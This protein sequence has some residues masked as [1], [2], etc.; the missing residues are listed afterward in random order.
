MLTRRALAGPIF[1]AVEDGSVVVSSKLAP[2]V[3]ALRRRP[4]ISSRYLAWLLATEAPEDLAS[5]TYEGV[6]RVPTHHVV[7]VWPDGRRQSALC[8]H[9]VSPADGITAT[10]AAREIRARVMRVVSRHL[11]GRR[12]VAILAGGGVDSS[13]V[14][15]SAVA[16]ARG[17]R[18]PEIEAIALHFRGPGDDRPYMR[19]LCRALG[20]VPTQ[21]SPSAGGSLVRRMMV[22]DG[23]P[24]T[25]PNTACEGAVLLTALQHGAEIAIGGVG[26]D[27][28]FMGKPESLATWATEGAPHRA[29][30][31]AI[32]L[33]VDWRDP[34][35]AQA[36]HFVVRPL[37]VRHVPHAV[38]K[39]RRRLRSRS[40]FPWA[41]GEFRFCVD[42]DRDPLLTPPDS[43]SARY[44][45]FVTFPYLMGIVD[46][47]AQAA[48]DLGIERVDPLLDDELVEF[49]AS[50]PPHL[51]LHGGRT[52]GLF[53]EAMEG[54]VPDAVRLRV[55]KAYFE[56]AMA[57]TVDAG[58]GF[59]ALDDLAMVRNLERLG[60]VD[61][62]A[63]RRAFD[64]LARDPEGRG[65]DWI[66]VWPTLSVEAFLAGQP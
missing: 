21:V 36:W 58:G 4:I 30:R 48:A 10:E 42:R 45:R 1:Y 5:T 26:G 23:E 18:G 60:F 41:R 29:I 28:L 44:T 31:A 54:L 33:R 51:L 15:A 40:N 62:K 56:P 50:L 19:E 59:R 43:A 65:E 61:A 57:A 13:A 7:H 20:I 27:D 3:A 2:L 34:G 35:L 64:A 25:S 39:L 11:S 53:R 63:F 17:A 38:R 9:A 66:N 22:L 16:F 8:T 6:Y 49:V 47:R 32:R 46:A 14:L 55:D 24:A 37:L 12:R 52:R